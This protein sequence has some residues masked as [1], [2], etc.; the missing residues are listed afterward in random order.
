MDH[1]RRRL[2][3]CGVGA[4]AAAAAAALALLAGPAGPGKDQ[5]VALA[6]LLLHQRHQAPRPRVSLLWLGGGQG[7]GQRGG[8]RRHVGARAQRARLRSRARQALRLRA[9]LVALRK[10]LQ[11]FKVVRLQGVL[12][13]RRGAS[14][15]VSHRT[16]SKRQLHHPAVGDNGRG[17]GAQA[18]RAARKARVRRRRRAQR[19]TW[20]P[21]LALQ[22]AVGLERVGTGIRAPL[23]CKFGGGRQQAQAGGMPVLLS[24]PSPKPYTQ[25]PQVPASTHPPSTRPPA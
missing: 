23:G 15:P 1:Q 25:Q 8:Q 7:G 4:L 19:G 16:A 11:Q 14:C 3:L 24:I 20:A 13:C 10:E 12:L 6:P 5:V 22:L 21:Q 17:A 9:E 18:Q 2:A